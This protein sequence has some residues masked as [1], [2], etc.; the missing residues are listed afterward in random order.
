MTDATGAILTGIA[1]LAA[2]LGGTWEIIRR[3]RNADPRRGPLM[4][5]VPKKD[6]WWIPFVGGIV[7]LMG[8]AWITF[9]GERNPPGLLVGLLAGYLFLYGTAARTGRDV[10]SLGENKPWV[11]A[12]VGA[13]FVAFGIGLIVVAATSAT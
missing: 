3:N 4:K 2:V 6:W 7:L 12:A 11:H 9:N 10:R 1:G 5:A 13:V 8:A